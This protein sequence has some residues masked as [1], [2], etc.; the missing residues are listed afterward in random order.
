MLGLSAD[1]LGQPQLRPRLRVPAHG[2]DPAGAVPVP[3]RERRLPVERQAPAGVE[4]LP[5]LRLR[6][7]QAGRG[8]LHPARAADADLP[9]LPRPVQ[10]HRSGRGDQRG[11]GEA[12]L[13]GQGRTRS[14]PSGTWAA[15]GRDR[16]TRSRRAR[17]SSSRT[18]STGVDA[19]F[20]GHTHC[21]VHHAPAQ[22]HARD[23][24]ARTRASASTA[25]G[26]RSTR[27]RRR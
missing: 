8:R 21:R 26:S 19:V 7:L 16:S 23:R 2:A 24:D 4:G 12:A 5:G 10:G 6:R 11:G 3:D 9:R 25:S 22:R 14:S 27:T 1:T 20:G 15:T 17:S 13:E 18:T